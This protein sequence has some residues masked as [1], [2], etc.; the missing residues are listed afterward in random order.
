M[1]GLIS[2]HVWPLIEA[3]RDVDG[4]QLVAVAEPRSQLRTRLA[5]TI[6]GVAEYESHSDLFDSA[7]VEAILVCVDNAAKT[8]VV[9]AAL[10]RGIAVYQDKPLAATGTQAA[11]IADA[12]RT[13]GGT[14]MCAFHTAFDPLYDEVGDLIRGG[15]IG[16]V[17]FARGLAGHAGFQAM[18]VSAEFADWLTDVKRG[19][20]GSFVD[21]AGYLLTTLT[22]YLGPAARVVGFGARD[23]DDLP[24]GIEDGTAALVEFESGALGSV[25]TRWGQVGPL[26][27][28]YSFHGTAGTLTCYHDRYQVVTSERTVLAGWSSVPAPAGLSGWRRDVEPRTSY[29]AEA[30]HFVAHLRSG[31]G[32]KR[33]VSAASALH[34]QQIIDA[35]YASLSSGAV[36][37]V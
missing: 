17:R 9:P 11:T 18:G 21:Q 33:A 31:R 7:D 16:R 24:E 32:L 1:V 5:A 6:P 26:P 2:D 4:V 14:V 13:T 22:D 28:K 30:E 8:E 27:L 15:L 34:V 36:A 19:G 10:E 23:D 37:G 35:Y 12:V 29:A 20:G 25:D 3:L